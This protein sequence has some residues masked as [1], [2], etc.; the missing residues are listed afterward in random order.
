MIGKNIE[1]IERGKR[2]SHKG[3]RKG[4]RKRGKK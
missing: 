1:M 3:G 2:M 4:R